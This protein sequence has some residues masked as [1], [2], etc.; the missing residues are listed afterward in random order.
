VGPLANIL[1]VCHP[2]DSFWQTSYTL[3]SLIPLWQQRGHE[4]A[5]QFGWRERPA[6]DLVIA[7]VDLTW[8]P[9]EA[10]AFFDAY[11]NVVNR[12]IVDVS[13]RRV[14]SNLMR[15]GDP[16][17][18]PV[19]VKT[20]A[21]CFGRP[22]RAREERPSRLVRAWRRARGLIEEPAAPYLGTYPVFD[23]FAAVPRRLVRDRG[24]V[25]EKFLPERDG[26]LYVVR[27]WWVFGD[28]TIER[29]LWGPK[30]MVKSPDVLRREAR[31]VSPPAEL[32]EIRRAFGL[33]YGKIDFVRRDGRAVVLDVTHTPTG[34]S[35]AERDDLVAAL[36]G[37]IDQ[38]V[39][40]GARALEARAEVA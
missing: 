4:V 35:M 33:D 2:R 26:D 39:P 40:A 6:A 20:D 11:P 16:W 10:R 29:V 22:D 19:M 31:T 9:A 14:S 37:G 32:T 5:V 1:I 17:T 30:P 36:A 12:R 38:F 15:P 27:Q 8:L 13:K 23:S 25:V 3:R 21:N 7:H 18:G 24:L 34:R 28:A